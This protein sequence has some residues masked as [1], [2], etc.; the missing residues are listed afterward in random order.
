MIVCKDFRCK[1]SSPI[2]NLLPI[3]VFITKFHTHLK[4]SL[5]IR[6]ANLRLPNQKS[7]SNHPDIISY[8]HKHKVIRVQCKA[9]GSDN[10]EALALPR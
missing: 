1:G 5:T 10:E 6:A 9:V 8:I 4:R 2:L 3:L 7:A